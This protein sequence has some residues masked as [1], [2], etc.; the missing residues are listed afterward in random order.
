MTAPTLYKWAL[1]VAK[2]YRFQVEHEG[3]ELVLYSPPVRAP[4]AWTPDARGDAADILDWFRRNG[5]DVDAYRP[6]EDHD[7]D[8]DGDGED[9]DGPNAA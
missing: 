3:D 4:E 9:Y 6:R 7:A 8:C 1:A 2:A 5:A